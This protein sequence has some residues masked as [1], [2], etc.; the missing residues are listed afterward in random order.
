VSVI[1]VISGVATAVVIFIALGIDYFTGTEWAFS[2]LMFAVLVGALLEFYRMAGK[3]G[4]APLQ[5]LGVTLAVLY[6]GFVFVAQHEPIF[7]DPNMVQ[8][9]VLTLGVM[10]VL[11]NFL[12]KPKQEDAFESSLTTIFGLVYVVFLG[13]YL[14]RIRFQAFEWAFLFVCTAKS[15]DIG[16]Y[17]IGSS[18]GK[19]G[20]HPES[21]KK[22]VEGSVAGIAVGTGIALLVTILFLA[23]GFPYH[24]A[25]IYGVIISIASQ[26]GDL[27]ESLIK[28]RCRV[29][30]SANLIPGSGGMLDFVDCL[31]FS[32]PVAYFFVEFAV[33]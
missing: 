25:V 4:Y 28:R 24:L 29:K 30:D 33:K 23:P 10:A 12:I 8:N 27:A 18:V 22:T 15:C 26:V 3:R 1:K 9:L 6:L 21:P 16:A 11:I 32:A 7:P 19:H 17:L 31:L 14:L 5:T 20:F 2:A 13:G